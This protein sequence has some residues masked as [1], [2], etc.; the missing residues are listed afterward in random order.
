MQIPILRGRS[1]PSPDTAQN[2]PVCIINATLAQRYFAGQDAVGRL[3]TPDPGEFG[4]TPWLIV[5]VIGDVKHFGAAE[6]AHPEVY[7]PFTQDGFPLIA[8]TARTGQQPMALANSMREAIWTVDKDQAIFRVLSMEEAAWESSAL[9]RISMII[10]AFFAATALA[11]SALGIFG[12][13]AYLVA[14][15]TREIGIRMALDAQRGAIVR[16]VVR[17]SFRVSAAG[18]VLGVAG[19]LAATRFL[20]SLLFQVRALDPMTFVAGFPPV[21]AVGGGGALGGPPPGGGAGR[22]PG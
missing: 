5:G 15:R 2:P 21:G 11:L 4:K 22:P 6:A 20:G 8:F 19:A 14:Q 1:F 18:L 13:V 16:M 17:Q 3:L 7:R 10:F 9:R 12:V